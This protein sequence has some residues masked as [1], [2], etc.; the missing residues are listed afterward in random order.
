MGNVTVTLLGGFAAAVDGEA[1]PEAAWRLKKARELVKLLALAPGH[2]LHRE[3]AMDV[4]WR[5]R[6]PAAAANNLHQAVHV[7]R[8]ALDADAIELRDEV[9]LLTADVDVDLFEL[10][11][12]DARRAGTPAAYRAALELYGGELLPENRYEDWAEA[13]RGELAELAAELADEVAAFGP[14]AERTFGLPADASS[15]IG[16]SRELAELKGLLQRTRMLTLTG[17]GG[18]GKTRLA[19]ELARAAEPAY[20][21]GAAIVELASLADARLVPDA[22]AAALDVRALSGQEPLDAVA[23]FL[24]TRSALV[25]LDNCEHLLAAS[26]LT[27]EALLRAAP[28]L[29]II[30]TS[31]QPLRVPGEVVFRVPS[32]GIPDPELGLAPAELLEFEAVRLFTERAA[33]AAPTFTLEADNATDVARICFRLDGL[34]LALELAAGRLGALSPAAIAERLDDRFRLLRS[35][36]HAAPTRQQTLAATLQWS[37]DLLD[38][39][40]RILLRRLAIFAGGFELEAVETVCSGGDLDPPAIADLLARLVEKS[41]VTVDDGSRERRYRLLETVRLYVRERLDQAGETAGLA[42][43]HARWAL[44]LAERERDAPRLDRN[45]ANLRAALGTLLDREPRDAL[46]LCVALLPFWMRRIDLHEG[47]R[48]FARALPAA[49]ERTRLRAE[50]LLAAAAIDFRSGALPASTALGEES[51]A[52]AAELGDARFEWRALQFLG[53][54][55]VASDAAEVAARR[56]EEAYE[57]ARREG[58]AGPEAIGVYS[59]GVTRWILGDLEGAERLVAESIDRFRALAGSPELIPSPVNFAEITSEQEGRPGL[60]LVF[61]DTLQPFFEISCDAA[62]SYALANESSIA[63]ARGDFGRAHELLDESAARF[64]EAG[65]DRGRAVVLVRRAYVELAEGAPAR[66]RANL[67]T[68]LE[69]R[70]QLSDQR[71][72]GL[73]LSGLGFIDTTAGDYRSAERHLA[74]AHEI[75]Q[76]AGDRWG[77]ASTL[78]RTADLALARGRLDDAERALEEARAVLGETQRE[79]WIANTLSGLAEVAL[80]RG[81]P[82]RASALLTDARDRYAARDDALGLANVEERLRSLAKAPL[83]PGEGAPVRTPRRPKTKGRKP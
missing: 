70:R 15:F 83:S 73:A 64:E 76:R 18:A 60:R 23:D 77:L 65:D 30:A 39:D 50:G 29:T 62:V 71:G 10:A 53:E 22:V 51:L 5:D 8:R 17:T 41:L 7:A 81:D 36:S 4:L 27:A 40:E 31:R 38:A 21:A 63:R 43:R 16:R 59:L 54:C 20:P 35:G 14:A 61:E 49:P 79:R 33:A 2:R 46:R 6:G 67:E 47:R 42:E 72:F 52:L 3:Q 32:L 69:L 9:L 82:D 56:L 68:A 37:H 19:L 55:G 13:R 58:F 44:G 66:A 45:A 24:A 26:A 75:F 11:A 48:W 28:Q 78:W 34:P 57:L 80:L 1:V 12:A 74:E 25:V